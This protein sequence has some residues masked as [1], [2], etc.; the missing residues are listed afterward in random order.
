MKFYFVGGSPSLIAQ[1][2]ADGMAG[3]KHK[4]ENFGHA[5][6]A[7]EKEATDWQRGGCALL[8]EDEFNSIGFTKDELTKYKTPGSRIN[9]PKE[10]A[11]KM[12]RAHFLFSEKWQVL[13]GLKKP[14]PK[15]QAPA[16]AE[17]AKDAK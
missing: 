5:I 1:V 3:A 11:E 8:T 12:Q 14:E 6:D 9:A 16:P 7:D 17:P 4:L 13:H 10:F 2:S 15:P